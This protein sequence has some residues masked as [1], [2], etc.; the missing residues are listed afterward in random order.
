M[1][2]LV[3]VCEW[4]NALE[5]MKAS[6]P[7]QGSILVFQKLKPSYNNLNDSA[8]QQLFLYCALYPANSRIQREDLIGH[9]IVE[10]II[11]GTQ[12]RQAELDKGH[13][14]LNRIENVSCW[15]VRQTLWVVDK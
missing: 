15:K 12:T 2:G 7:W 9:L 11:K 14:M 10:G 5:D 4:R 13:S 8:L 3:D 6:I 1:R